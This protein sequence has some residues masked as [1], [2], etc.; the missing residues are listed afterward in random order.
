MVLLKYTTEYLL[1][2]LPHIP[3]NNFSPHDFDGDAI[4]CGK[5]GSYPLVPERRPAQIFTV[6]LCVPLAG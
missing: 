1:I 3:R 4:P 6:N 5:D 2:D